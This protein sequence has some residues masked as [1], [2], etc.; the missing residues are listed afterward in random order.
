MNK[1]EDEST[2]VYEAI[3]VPESQYC[4]FEERLNKWLEN[5]AIVMTDPSQ[6]K[7]KFYSQKIN[8]Q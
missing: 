6:K 2:P 3:A 5:N 1:F 4:S 7:D 8:K